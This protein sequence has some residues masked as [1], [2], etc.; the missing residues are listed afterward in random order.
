MLFFIFQGYVVDG[1]LEIPWLLEENGAATPRPQIEEP[2]EIIP[3]SPAE[4][5]TVDFQD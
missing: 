1:Q 4:E 5:I 3:T 2:E